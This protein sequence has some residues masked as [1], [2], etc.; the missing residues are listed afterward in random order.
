MLVIS[1]N[2]KRGF[3]RDMALSG[4]IIFAKGCHFRIESYMIFVYLFEA[5]VFLENKACHFLWNDRDHVE[6]QR[7]KIGKKRFGEKRWNG[8][9]VLRYSESLILPKQL[10][11]RA[12]S[13]KDLCCYF[14]KLYKGSVFNMTLCIY[15]CVV[16]FY[17]IG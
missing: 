2:Y 12:V 17:E 16:T 3:Q 1:D 14:E 13:G 15:A 11:Q 6:F 8:K 9:T 5:V 7:K 10:T 4:D